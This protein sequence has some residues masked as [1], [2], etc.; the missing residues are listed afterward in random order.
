MIKSSETWLPREGWG[1]EGMLLAF[2]SGKVSEETQLN[3]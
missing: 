2:P 1:M 3:D